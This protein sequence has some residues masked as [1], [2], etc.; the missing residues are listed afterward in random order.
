MLIVIFKKK[1]SRKE[2]GALTEKGQNQAQ[3]ARIETKRYD[4]I[5][6]RVRKGAL[7]KTSE[8]E[9]HSPYLSN[10]KPH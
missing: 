2:T 7:R 5:I 9:S 10:S 8:E 4:R 3:Q 1:K 6:R